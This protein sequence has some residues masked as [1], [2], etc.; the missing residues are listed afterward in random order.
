MVV[1]IIC[2]KVKR[3]ILKLSF[4]LFIFFTKKGKCSKFADMFCN[5]MHLSVACYQIGFSEKKKKITGF[6]LS[7]QDKDNILT[8]SEIVL[9]R[10]HLKTSTVFQ[11]VAIIVWGWGWIG[12]IMFVTYK[13]ST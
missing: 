7:L 10:E 12:K 9:L 13:K 5:V 4:F 8:L 3:V 11:N 2:N 1:E 6:F